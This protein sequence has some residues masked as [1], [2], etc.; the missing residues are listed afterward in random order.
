MQNIIEI[1]LI[2]QFESF[3]FDGS[4]FSHNSVDVL[5]PIHELSV[6]LLVFTIKLLKLTATYANQILLFDNI[7]CKLPNKLILFDVHSFQ[8]P[9]SLDCSPWDQ[10]ND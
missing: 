8:F 1:T 5:P 6:I 3:E 4:I 7:I 9:S 2:V 10:A